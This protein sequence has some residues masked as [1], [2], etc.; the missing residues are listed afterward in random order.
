MF[1]RGVVDRG[2][3]SNL[4]HALPIVDEP[5][6]VRS[7]PA[8]P[9]LAPRVRNHHL[10]THL[11]RHAREVVTALDVV[12]ARRPA[13]LP[14]D[15]DARGK[16]AFRAGDGSGTDVDVVGFMRRRRRFRRRVRVR[17]RWGGHARW[18]RARSSVARGARRVGARQSVRAPTWRLLVSSLTLALT[19]TAAGLRDTYN[20]KE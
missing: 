5:Q 20:Y 1:Q 14:G 10:L 4:R 15:D 2:K 18:Y 19:R 8:K 9:A 6:R 17:M 11:L 7:P 12:A 16:E 13:Q 3:P